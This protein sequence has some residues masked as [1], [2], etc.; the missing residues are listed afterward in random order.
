MLPVT[1]CGGLDTVRGFCIRAKE[2][3]LKSFLKM[4]LF[5]R[6]SDRKVINAEKCWIS[7]LIVRQANNQSTC[8]YSTCCIQ[9]GVGVRTTLTSWNLKRK[10][11]L[12]WPPNRL[13]RRLWASSELLSPRSG[14]TCRPAPPDREMSRTEGKDMNILRIYCLLQ[15]FSTRQPLIFVQQPDVTPESIN[16]WFNWWTATK[17]T[18]SAAGQHRLIKKTRWRNQPLSG[19][20]TGIMGQHSVLSGIRGLKWFKAQASWKKRKKALDQQNLISVVNSCWRRQGL[21]WVVKAE[22][23]P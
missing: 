6:Q 3:H 12:S 4:C 9:T 14:W 13:W 22:S 16:Q 8:M 17:S 7:A 1:Y 11:G 2:A 15:F 18:A 19:K 10:W 23:R 21:I 20:T 5:Y